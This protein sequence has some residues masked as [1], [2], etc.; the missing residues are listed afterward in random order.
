MFGLYM[1]IRNPHYYYFCLETMAIFFLETMAINHYIDEF[2]LGKI[3]PK[4]I[5]EI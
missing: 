4:Y 3:V 2:L 1:N 5:F